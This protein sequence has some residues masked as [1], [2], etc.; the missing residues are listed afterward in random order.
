MISTSSIIEGV[1][2]SAEN[3]IIWKNRKG[4]AK[5]DD[6]TYK[7]IIGRSGRMFKH[8]IG[9][10]Y[11]LEEP[12]LESN[13]QLDIPFPE[14]ILGDLGDTKYESLLTKEQIA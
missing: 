2:T 4:N 9:K 5:L 10:I 7:N 3:V 12:P 13:T 11:I 14:E 6:F 8:F 1:N